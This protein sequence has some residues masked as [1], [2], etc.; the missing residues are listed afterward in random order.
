MI[1]L[2]HWM[3]IFFFWKVLKEYLSYGNAF[4]SSTKCPFFDSLIFLSNWTFI[5]W[6]LNYF[7]EILKVILRYWKRFFKFNKM[8]FFSQSHNSDQLNVYIMCFIIFF[9]KFYKEYW[10]VKHVFAS[11]AKCTNQ[12]FFYN[13][14]KGLFVTD[15]SFFGKFQ[16]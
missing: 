5:L 10:K 15:C 8:Y 4:L 3:F 12:L 2:T 16:V 11:L 14:I 13:F 6:V 1:Y 9:W 7:L